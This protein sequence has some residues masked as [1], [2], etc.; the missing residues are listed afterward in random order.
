[1]TYSNLQ[2]PIGKTIREDTRDLTSSQ[3]VLPYAR[4]HR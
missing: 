3:C 4:R 1:M 2:F